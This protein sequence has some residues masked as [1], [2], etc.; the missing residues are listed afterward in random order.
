MPEDLLPPEV[1]ARQLL[2]LARWCGFAPAVLGTGSLAGWLIS[3]G[4]IAEVGLFYATGMLA[5]LAGLLLLPPAIWWLFRAMRL[6]VL[7]RQLLITA[8]LLASNLPLAVLCWNIASSLTALQIIRVVNES[9]QPAG[10]VEVWLQ[11]PRQQS[12]RLRIPLLQP[13]ST[14]VRACLYGGEGVAEFRATHA[15][16]TLTSTPDNSVFLGVGQPTEAR[17]TLSNGG[18]YRFEGFHNPRWAWLDALLSRL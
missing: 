17:L 11:P 12:H 18:Q 4:V 14:V 6:K 2:R 7:P 15:G 10:P 5:I 9:D 13:H 3:G 8:T 16:Q 1:R